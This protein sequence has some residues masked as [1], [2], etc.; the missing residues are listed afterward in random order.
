MDSKNIVSFSLAAVQRIPNYHRLLKELQQEG[1]EYVSSTTIGNKLGLNP[2]LVKKD[3]SLVTTVEGKPRL[4]YNISLLI[5]DIES[6]LGYDNTKDAVII[7]VGNLG[8]AL[9]RY[10]GFTHY[11]INICLGFDVDSNVIGTVINGVTIMPLSKLEDLINRLHVHIAILTVPKQVAQEIADRLSNTDI[12]AIWNWAPIQLKVSDN[13]AVKNE[14]IA[15][16][17]AVLTNKMKDI[18]KD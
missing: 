3:L 12:R 8:Q 9:L 16:S 2:I 18:L 10:P 11:G 13:I 14:D 17:L 4:G 5:K 6:F 15:S 1:D 7:G